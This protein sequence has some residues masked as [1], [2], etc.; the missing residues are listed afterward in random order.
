MTIIT[1]TIDKMKLREAMDDIV[2]S[3]GY[4]CALP[5]PSSLKQELLGFLHDAHDKLIDLT[6]ED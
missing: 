3:S 4:V 5:I 1:I 2:K 6:R